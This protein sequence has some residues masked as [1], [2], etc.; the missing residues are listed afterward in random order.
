MTQVAPVSLDGFNPF[1]SA[2]QQCPHQY[3]RAMQEQAP[4]FHVEGTDLYMVTRHEMITPIL[5]DTQTFSNRFGSAGEMPKGDVVE[6][7]KEVLA[8]GWTQVPT[9]LTIDPPDHTR[10]RGTVA[11][12]FN[13]KRMAELRA[14]IEAIVDRLIDGFPDDVFDVVTS[15][16]IPV[17]IAA[18]AII[19]NVPA[20]RMADFKRWSDDSIANIGTVITDD[21]RVEAY[22]G[23]VEFQHYFA[24]QLESRRATRADEAVDDLMSSLVRAEIDVDP[25]AVGKRPLIMEEMLSILQQLLVAGNETTTK[26]ITEGLMLLATHP[27]VWRRLQADP[28]GYAPLVTEE[29]L[30]LSTP[31]QG[32]FRLTTR[33]VELEGVHVPKG[34]RLVLVYSGANRDPRVW[35]DDPDRFDPDRPNLKDHLAF[36]KGIHFCLGAPLSRVEMQVAFEH[37]ARRIERIELV[38][39]AELRYHP[40]FMLRGLERLD[41]RLVKKELANV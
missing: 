5:R 29:V 6:R 21:R 34:S 12:Y 24:E 1:N 19:L 23:I 33:D 28:A 16:A 26:A 7:I 17:P 13:P 20:D 31:T 38:D 32:M 4:V 37:L 27:D 18:I 40:S 36:G 3:Y 22:R 10:F 15:F 2:V 8:S 41:A 35:G 11:A 14:P 30:R 39:G 9:M 25:P